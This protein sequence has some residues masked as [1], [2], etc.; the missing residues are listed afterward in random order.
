MAEKQERIFPKGVFAFKP[1]DKAPSFVKGSLVI[2]LEDL[3]AFVN[4]EGKQYLTEYN[5]KRQ[6]KLQITENKDNGKF[7]VTVD[8]YRKGADTNYTA[9][10]QNNSSTTDDSQ[11][12]PF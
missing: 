12:L 2:T 11:D 7:A 5:G 9:P 10:A 3:R 1:N 4:G 6:L 8:T